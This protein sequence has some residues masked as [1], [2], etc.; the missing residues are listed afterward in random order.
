MVELEE[1]ASEVK[2]FRD[3]RGWEKF[4]TPKELAVSISLESSELLELFQWKD[5]SLKDVDEEQLRYEMEDVMIYLLSLSEITGID[6][7]EAVKEKLD[8][9]RKKYPPDE[10]HF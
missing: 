7:E 4:H 1:L 5:C 6:L 9:N 3:E 2:E 10:E 8:K